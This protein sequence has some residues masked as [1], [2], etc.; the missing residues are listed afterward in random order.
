[1]R[2]WSIQI[3]RLGTEPGYVEGWIKRLRRGSAS[4]PFVSD[5]SPDT[6]TVPKRYAKLV[7]PDRPTRNRARLCR[8]MDQAV[9]TRLSVRAVRQRW[10]SRYGNGTEAVCE[11]GRSRSPDS[12]PSPAMSRDGSS[13]CDAAQRPGRSSA[14]AVPIR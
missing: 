4:G 8:G 10:Q 9:A 7:D 5:G 14:M 11:T 12:E 1:M 2:N 13:G 3:T 6:V